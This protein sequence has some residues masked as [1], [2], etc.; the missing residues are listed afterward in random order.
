MACSH[1]G[2]PVSITLLGGSISIR[3]WTNSDEAYIRQVSLTVHAC[4]GLPGKPRSK[5]TITATTNLVNLI[6]AQVHK[7][8][9][10]VFVPGCKE[11]VESGTNYRK[12]SR[13]DSRSRI[14]MDLHELQGT[15][16]YSV[17]DAQQLGGSGGGGRGRPQADTRPAPAP[18]EG[19][20]DQGGRA[21]S[22][23]RAIIRCPA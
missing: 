19:E 6:L 10:L 18:Q 17:E 2:E 7:W 15:H 21:S 13:H 16:T 8:L 22:A 11:K 5:G 23:A 1:A 14:L 3:G 4:S 20:G 12:H 9:E